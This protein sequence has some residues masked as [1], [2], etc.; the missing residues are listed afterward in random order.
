MPKTASK[1]PNKYDPKVRLFS[2]GGKRKSLRGVDELAFDPFEY[3]RR[4]ALF[5]RRF[6]AAVRLGINFQ[7][8][9]AF[10]IKLGHSRCSTPL[11]IAALSVC[12]VDLAT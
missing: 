5:P 11:V 7:D 12:S 8:E 2:I 9:R 6:S 4:M 10:I 3:D 1:K